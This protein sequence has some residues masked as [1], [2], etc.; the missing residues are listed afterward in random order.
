M[1]L[2]PGGVEAELERL[3]LATEALRASHG[4][5]GRVLAFV[6]AESSF[7]W[8]VVLASAARRVVPLAVIAAAVAVF[9]ARQSQERAN[10]AIAVSYGDEEVEW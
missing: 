7:G 1:T 4:F 6:E 8:M 2:K 9:F 3:R 5:A 10:E